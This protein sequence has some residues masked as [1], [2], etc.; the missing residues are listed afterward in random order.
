VQTILKLGQALSLEVVA[1]GVETAEDMAALQ[2]L[3]C[4][5][6]QGYHLK[7][8]AARDDVFD[9]LEKMNVGQATQVQS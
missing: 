3:G 6:M 2:T 1:E 4:E 7:P 5:C 9:W 8:P